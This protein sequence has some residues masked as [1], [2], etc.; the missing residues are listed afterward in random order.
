MSGFGTD[1]ETY[2][3]RSAADERE[4]RTRSPSAG[5]LRDPI[6]E[7][8][9]G[10]VMPD[11]QSPGLW[12]LEV[13]TS[14]GPRKFR[15]ACEYHAGDAQSETLSDVWH[16]DVW[17]SEGCSEMNRFLKVV[18][19]WLGREGPRSSN[20][21]GEDRSPGRP[22]ETPRETPAVP[23][24]PSSHEV[25]DALTAP[26]T[27]RE[28]FRTAVLH[29]EAVDFDPTETRELTPL[30]R[31][32]IE[33]YRDSN[34]PTDLIAVGSAIRTFVAYA[35]RDEAFDFAAELLKT[36]VR[37]PLP[38]GLEIEVSKMAVRKLT[39]RPPTRPN[40][41]PELGGRLVELAET[42]L[43]PRLIAREKHGAVALNAVLG[44]VLTRDPRA[45]EIIERVRTL[46]APW[47]QQVVGRRAGKLVS[48]LTQRWGEDAHPELVR[49]LRDLVGAAAPVLSK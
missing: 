6:E 3:G 15:R 17:S 19:D 8:R 48:E 16:S 1:P 14:S 18:A 38:I 34:D 4:D 5:R 28:A 35:A 25:L 46:G 44:V 41:N 11:E 27:T 47:F 22:A 10:A 30:L 36:S 43:N 40:Q 13:G 24:E 29:A 2:G 31:R 45:N 49:S 7:I 12:T 32:F 33:Q 42:Y 21:H 37:A 9:S 23:R 26:D 20:V 39:T